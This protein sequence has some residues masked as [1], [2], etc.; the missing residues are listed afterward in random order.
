MRR[1]D[2]FQ[3]QLALIIHADKFQCRVF[4]FCQQLPRHDI[5]VMFQHRRDDFIA[6][7][8]IGSAPRIGHKVDRF[9]C[10]ACIDYFAVRFGVDELL[11]LFARAFVAF[12][13]F[14]RQIV[15]AA[16]NIRI[17]LA[18]IFVERVDHHFRFLRCGGAIEIDERL[19]VNE[20]LQNRKVFT[21]GGDVQTRV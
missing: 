1:L 15:H 18:I 21:N 6:L 5:G 11:D 9:G 17:E 8:D 13:R 7:L 2:I 19:A 16:M 14:F 4:F 3:A 12:R 10:I 20:L